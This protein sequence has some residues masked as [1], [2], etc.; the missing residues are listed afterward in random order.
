MIRAE[1]LR[2]RLP[3]NRSLKHPA[4]PPAVK[5]AT[6]H[7]ESDDAPR[8]LI[9]HRQYPVRAQGGGLAPEQVATPQA[10]LG[11]AEKR[12]PGR[13]RRIRFRPVV[14]AEDTAHHILING[15]SER[16]CDLLSDSRAA[17]SRIPP[18]HSTPAAMSSL[19]GRLGPP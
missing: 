1:V 12:E 11:V 10:V 5:G 7:A 3:A 18:F 6:V 14:N 4:H 2:Q 13:A 8:K 17:P 16:Q 19:V 15:D 9:H